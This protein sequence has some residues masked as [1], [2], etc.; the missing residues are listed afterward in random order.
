MG[1]ADRDGTLSRTFVGIIY[2]FGQK[3]IDRLAKL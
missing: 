3:T 1:C 2:L